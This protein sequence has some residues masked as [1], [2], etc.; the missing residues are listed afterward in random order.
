[1]KK[2]ILLSALTTLAACETGRSPSGAGDDNCGTT[3]YVHL[4]GAPESDVLAISFNQPV[5]IIS[6]RDNITMD[7]LPN[8]LNFVLD[9]ASNVAKITCG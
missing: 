8:R 6:P 2:A 1:M 7:F 4:Q 5:R 3:R 9:A